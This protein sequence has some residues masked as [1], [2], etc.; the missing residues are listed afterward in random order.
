[1]HRA[2][3]MRPG[4]LTDND[5]GIMLIFLLTLTCFHCTALQLI[6]TFGGMGGGAGNRRWGGGGGGFGGAGGGFTGS[7]S[8]PLGGGRG[9]F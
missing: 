4:P 6:S 2:C 7:N 5:S 8:I 3:L 9:G 1:V